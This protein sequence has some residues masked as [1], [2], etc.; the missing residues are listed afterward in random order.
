VDEERPPNAEEVQAALLRLRQ[1]HSKSESQ[2]RDQ[3]RLPHDSSV[4]ESEPFD[5]GEFGS[6]N[7]VLERWRNDSRWFFCEF[8]PLLRR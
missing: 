8:Q 2:Y 5:F 3:C 1:L 6:L 7:V 4:R